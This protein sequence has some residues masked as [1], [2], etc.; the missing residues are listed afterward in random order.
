[1]HRLASSLPVSALL[2]AVFSATAPGQCPTL[3]SSAA[4]SPRLVGDAA[5][6]TV[7]DPDGTG[8]LPFRW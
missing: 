5:C 6:T 7:W 4:P 3:W 1:M 2:G 8:P